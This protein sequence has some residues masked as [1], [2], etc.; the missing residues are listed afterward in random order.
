MLD[1]L[2]ALTAINGAHEYFVDG[3]PIAVD[4]KVSGTW[5]TVVIFGSRRGGP[6]YY[7]L[8]ITDTTNPTFL[9]G[10]TDANIK[11]TWSEPAIGKVKIGST[12]KYVAF[13]GGGY[14]TPTNNAYGKG[15]FAVDIATGTKLWEYYKD[16]STDDRQYMS[17]SIPAN[18]TAVDLNN[19]GYIDHVYIGDVG[20][21]LWKFD[22]SATATTG[23]T[24]K[25]LFAASPSQAN[26]PA[27]GEYYPA[28]AIY[29]APSL[30]LD[31][32]RNVWVFF[33]TGDRNHPNASA[34]NRFYG[35][36]D[37]TTMANGATLTESN[38][39]D[40]TTSNAQP[41]QGW[42]V[43]LLGSGEKVL[44]ASNVF[45]MNVFFSSFT[46]DST[47]TCTGGG[48]TAKLYAV[49]VQSGYA[50]INFST[51]TA[52]ASPNASSTRSRDIG[53]GIASMPVVVITPP[54]TPGGTPESSVITATSNQELP[55][56]RVPPPALLKQVRSWHER[57]Q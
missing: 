40:V 19:D 14:N 52:L 9:W 43:R 42:Y 35:V 27:A 31:N 54:G 46:P 55:N 57:I 11:E 38:L 44:A 4:I 25:R 6:Y 12:D 21:Q 1:S 51:G 34:S 18:P 32:N 49:Q 22:V 16:G 30:A 17:F 37:N 8:D 36:K 47:V 26:P 41:T 39:V 29:G 20:G 28:Q 3:S 50:A 7:A 45:N 2:Q 56:N 33:G 5:K 13:F 23:W 53:H 15:F 10:F 24:G 48:G